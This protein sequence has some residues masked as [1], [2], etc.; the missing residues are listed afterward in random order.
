MRDSLAMLMDVRMKS[1]D[2][3]S[4][5]DGSDHRAKYRLIQMM[6]KVIDVVSRSCRRTAADG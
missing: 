5:A 4:R 3:S 2:L 1:R 6:E